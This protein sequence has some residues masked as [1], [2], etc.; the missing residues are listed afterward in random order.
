MVD[1]IGSL[2]PV[3]LSNFKDS[4]SCAAEPVATPPPGERAQDETLVQDRF[5]VSAHAGR[6]DHL[7][8]G[9][10]RGSGDWQTVRAK[11]PVLSHQEEELWPPTGTRPRRWRSRR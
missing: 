6:D 4:S 7:E 3:E 1:N 8:T 5:A 9:L 10:A 11:I 2:G